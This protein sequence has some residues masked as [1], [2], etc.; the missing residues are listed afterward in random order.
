MQN[1]NIIHDL[2]NS[3]T[4]HLTTPMPTRIAAPLSPNFAVINMSSIGRVVGFPYHLVSC[5]RPKRRR[6]KVRICAYHN[7]SG[8]FMQV[9]EKYTDT[10]AADECKIAQ[11]EH[12]EPKNRFPTLRLL[13][14]DADRPALPGAP[15]TSNYINAVY[16]DSYKR[17]NRFIVTQT[18]LQSTVDDFWTMISQYRVR[19]AV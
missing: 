7:V 11:S 6:Y 17:Q 5:L 18:P 16:V 14:R 12:N 19:S 1:R 3:L 13:S 9:L 10:P 15:A 2:R 8:S 4:S